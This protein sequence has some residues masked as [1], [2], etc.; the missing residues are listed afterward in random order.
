MPN[1]TVNSGIHLRE[2]GKESILYDTWNKKIHVLNRTAS[3]VWKQCCEAATVEE[4][5]QRMTESFDV[6]YQSALA[7]VQTI[8]HDFESLELLCRGDA[9]TQGEGKL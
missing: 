2:I 6:P 1:L 4:I 9:V 5:T 3:F 8:L 7:D